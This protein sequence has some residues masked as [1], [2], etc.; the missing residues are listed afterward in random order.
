MAIPPRIRADSVTTVVSISFFRCLYSLFPMH[1]PTPKAQKPQFLKA[2]FQRRPL[3]VTNHFPLWVWS[4]GSARHGQEKIGR[5]RNRSSV[6]LH[7]EISDP[8]TGL[9]RAR[10]NGHIRQKV[11]GLNAGTVNPV[12]R[13][14]SQS[15]RFHPAHFVSSFDRPLTCI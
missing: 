7:D 6:H 4:P 5:A 8:Q 14:V 9:E 15:G 13:P 11:V 10:R 2:V 3:P 1:H 12:T